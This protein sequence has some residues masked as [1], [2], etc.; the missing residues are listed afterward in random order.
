MHLPSS[1]WSQTNPICLL[2]VRIDHI[3][4][5]GTGRYRAHMSR[6]TSGKR[7]EALMGEWSTETSGKTDAK[8]L[9]SFRG[10]HGD[11]A[12]T[13][14]GNDGTETDVSFAIERGQETQAVA[15][16]L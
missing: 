10:F 3:Q 7:Y 15:I 12:A 16:Q 11:Y 13:A 2:N 1:G 14:T 4:L 6:T 8:G 9:L 5:T